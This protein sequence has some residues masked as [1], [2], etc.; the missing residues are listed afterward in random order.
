[1]ALVVAVDPVRTGLHARIPR[2]SERQEVRNIALPAAG[3]TLG[4][5][6]PL[7]VGSGGGHQDS[8]GYPIHPSLEGVPEAAMFRSH[9]MA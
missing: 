4:I 1:M 7:V 8:A 6:L 2:G 5:G 9:T 3:T